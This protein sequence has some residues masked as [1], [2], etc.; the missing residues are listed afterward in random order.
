MGKESETMGDTANTSDDVGKKAKPDKGESKIKV[1]FKG[2][3]AEYHKIVW[4]DKDTLFKQTVAVVAASVIIGFVIAALD[5]LIQIGFD[6]L[7]M[8]G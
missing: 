5:T 3:K 6:K 8:I 1:W 2:I 4:P 7:L